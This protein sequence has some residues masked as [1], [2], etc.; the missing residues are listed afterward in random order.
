MYYV[1][2]KVYD[3]GGNKCVPNLCVLYHVVYTRYYVMTDEKITCRG[4]AILSRIPEK[5]VELSHAHSQKSAA[6]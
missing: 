4:R 2:K 3:R 6:I 5:L 1:Y